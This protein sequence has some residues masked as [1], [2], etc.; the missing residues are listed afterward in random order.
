MW[1]GGRCFLEVASAPRLASRSPIGISDRRVATWRPVRLRS[2]VGVS[3]RTGALR[4][5]Q[6]AVWAS[7]AAL[8]HRVTP[9]TAILRRLS[10]MQTRLHSPGLGK[11]EVIFLGREDLELERQ[12]VEWLRE[13]NAVRPSRATGAPPSALIAAEQARLRPLALRRCRP[14]TSR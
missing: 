6:G 11:R 12:L 2:H 8:A 1:H 10:A 7:P 4:R 9:L 5:S 3:T 13:L 14:M